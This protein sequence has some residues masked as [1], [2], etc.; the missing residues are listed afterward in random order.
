MS[1]EGENIKE[2]TKHITPD[3]YVWICFFF[4]AWWQTCSL[5]RVDIFKSY[6]FTYRSVSYCVFEKFM[7]GTN[8]IDALNRLII[9]THHIYVYMYIIIFLLVYTI[10]LAHWQR[11]FIPLSSI[12][13]ALAIYILY[14]YMI[15]HHDGFVGFIRRVTWTTFQ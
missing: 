13:Y 9:T 5:R 2:K 6:F 14:V 10:V 4:N 15:Q 7:L 1:Q 8:T 12:R 3:F 11:K